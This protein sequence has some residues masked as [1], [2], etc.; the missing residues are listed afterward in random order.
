[1][2]LAKDTASGRMPYCWKAKRVPVRPMP[3]CTSSTSSSQSRSAHSTARSW[4]YSRSRGITPPSPC[5]SSSI[6]AHTSW[7]AAPWRASRLPASAYRKPS[8]KG[9]KEWCSLSC[10]VAVRV[11]M[12]RPWKEFFRVRMVPRPLPYLSKE[13]LRAS[14]MSPSLPS[15]PELPKKAAAR[16]ERSQR[17]WASL[18]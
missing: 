12:V 5:T 4:T 17:V 18:A 7:P 10:P 6:T 14:L 13:Y 11:V 8:G 16:P 15:A 1:M 9:K 3:V 2:P